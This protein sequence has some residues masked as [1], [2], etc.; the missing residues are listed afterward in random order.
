MK[1]ILRIGLNIATCYFLLICCLYVLGEIVVSGILG[2][3]LYSISTLMLLYMAN[4][5][6]NR[7]TFL[8]LSISKNLWSIKLGILV[9]CLYFL[10]REL[11]IEHAS[12]YG[13]LG[14]FSRLWA[15]DCFVMLIL[16]ILLDAIIKKLNMLKWR[17]YKIS[18]W[19]VFGEWQSCCSPFKQNN[20]S[21]YQPIT[22]YNSESS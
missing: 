2:I 19:N 6:F 11:L 16:S 17:R 22:A 21:E 12:E 13:I 7:I 18:L 15:I 4:L 5:G 3:I 8:K 10:G 1:F 14:G 9:L 20:L